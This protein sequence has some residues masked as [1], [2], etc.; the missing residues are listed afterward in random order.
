MNVNPDLR[1]VFDQY[2]KEY[3]PENATASAVLAV[4]QMI[5]EQ[6]AAGAAKKLSVKDVAV[7]LNV[8]E[9]TVRT[10]EKRG[11]LPAIRYGG[12]RGVLRFDPTVVAAYNDSLRPPKMSDTR[13]RR[14]LGEK[15]E[16]S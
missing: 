16:Q 8:S 1:D 15:P 2:L 5:L 12:G 9:D 7:L 6:R 4:G 13:R 14:L 10:M 11:K 3:G